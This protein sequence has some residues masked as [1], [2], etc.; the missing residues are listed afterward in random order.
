MLAWTNCR[1]PW[2]VALIAIFQSLAFA[3]GPVVTI[4]YRGTVASTDAMRITSPAEITFRLFTDALAG[5]LVWGETHED[6]TLTEGRFSVD[7]GDGMQLDPLIAWDAINPSLQNP[8]PALI[9]VLTGGVLFLEIQVGSE[10][11]LFPR[12]QLLYTPYAVFAVRAASARTTSAF[13]DSVLAGVYPTGAV[14]P[15]AGLAGIEGASIPEGWVLC[16]GRVLDSRLPEYGGLFAVIGRHYNQTAGVSDLFRVPDYRGYF[17]RGANADRSDAYR[18]EV[19]R[20]P[21]TGISNGD[22]VDSQVGT[23]Q[24]DNL[25]KHDHRAVREDLEDDNFVQLDESHPNNIV[26]VNNGQG[27]VVGEQDSDQTPGHANLRDSKAMGGGL[28]SVSLY[29]SRPVNATVHFIIKL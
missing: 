19:G 27:T 26:L 13:S 12:Q 5:R 24:E 29:E 9:E 17:L 1:I 22:P 20:V 14:V 21:I 15:F 28:G 4:P 10:K 7:L 6:I 3:Q 16:D 11:P 18:D 25:E 23:T 2:V 8:S